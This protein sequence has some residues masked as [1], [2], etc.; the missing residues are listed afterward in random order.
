[1][2]RQPGLSLPEIGGLLNFLYDHGHNVDIPVLSIIHVNIGIRPEI[3][4]LD[5]TWNH[6][7]DMLPFFGLQ[8]QPLF[9]NGLH[10]AIHVKDPL[11]NWFLVAPKFPDTPRLTDQ[12]R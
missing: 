10:C 3:T 12:D 1:M 8:N 2:W 4:S 7:E 11:F 6:H 5:R 9:T